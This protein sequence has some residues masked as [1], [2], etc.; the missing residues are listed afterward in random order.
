M[1]ISLTVL[2][3]IVIIIWLLG[4][5]LP[6]LPWPPLSFLGLLIIHRTASMQFSP[7]LLWILG[8]LAAFTVIMDYLIP[9][10]GTKRFGWSKAGTRWS[11]GWLI[12]GLLFFPPFGMIIWPLIGAFIGEY[13]RHQDKNNAL[14]SAWWSFV[15]FLL[16]TGIKIIVCGVMLWYG[17][18]G[19]IWLL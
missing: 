12:L 10:W 6:I 2:W 1:D 7:T 13:V 11:I 16:W 17:I 4:S 19:V 5:I 18:K 14:R 9:V 15:W 8:W 3:I